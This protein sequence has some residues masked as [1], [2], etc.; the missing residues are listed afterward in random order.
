MIQMLKEKEIQAKK[1]ENNIVEK[2]ELIQKDNK[3]LNDNVNEIKNSFFHNLN[4]IE[5]YFNK[6]Y[7]SLCRAVDLKET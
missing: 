4:E 3:K 7:Q 2:C 6:K 1:I 5:Q